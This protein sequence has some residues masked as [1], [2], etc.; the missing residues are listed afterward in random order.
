MVVYSML[1]LPRMPLR[2]LRPLAETAVLFPNLAPLARHLLPLVRRARR[3]R[4]VHRLGEWA[5]MVREAQRRA[6]SLAGAL[7]HS[8]LTRPLAAVQVLH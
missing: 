3:R 5:A 6:I 2:Y 4:A 8:R 7:L 1:Q